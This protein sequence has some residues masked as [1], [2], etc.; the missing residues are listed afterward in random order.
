MAFKTKDASKIIRLTDQKAQFVSVNLYHGIK[1]FKKKIS[2]D[3]LENAWESGNPARVMHVIPWNDLP[4]DIM[5]SLEAVGASAYAA[6][7]IAIESLPPNINSRLR[8]DVNNP[9][10]R[11]YITDRTSKMVVGINHETQQTIQNA[12]AHSFTSAQTPRQMAKSIKGS[13][14]LYP[15]QYVAL[16]NY[17]MK[18]MANGVQ[19]SKLEKMVDG[20]EDRLLAY[21]ARMIARTEIRAATN[22]GQLSMW[23]EGANQGLIDR[24]TAKRVWDCEGPDPCDICEPMDGVSVGLDEPFELPDG[25]T[26]EYPPMGTHPNCFCGSHLEM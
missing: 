6:G 24:S 26:C 15:A 10:L 20:Y 17:Q 22:L 9:G 12:V 5:P 8:W 23:R 1:K 3:Q 11:K 16:G 13:I 21:R 2:L 7:K 19:G 14:G 18:L 25:T 4:S